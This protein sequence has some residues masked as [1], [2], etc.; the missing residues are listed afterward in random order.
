MLPDSQPRQTSGLIKIIISAI[1]KIINE[2]QQI[3][4]TASLKTHGRVVAPPSPWTPAECGF[5]PQQVHDLLLLVWLK[6]TLS[7]YWCLK[8]YVIRRNQWAESHR[9]EVQ[10]CP[11][12]SEFCGSVG[13]TVWTFVMIRVVLTTSDDPECRRSKTEARRRRSAK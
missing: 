3:T 8:I 13:A 12:I 2:R 4:L 6:T 5:S 9:Q 11:L 7:F 10:T 1:S